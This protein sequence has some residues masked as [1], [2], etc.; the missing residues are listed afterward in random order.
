[1]RKSLLIIALAVFTINASAQVVPSPFWT[2]QS[3]NFSIVSAGIRYMHVVDPNVVWAVGYNGTSAASNFNEFTRTINGGTSYVSGLIYP[4]TAT[5]FPASIE[6]INADTAW[7]TAYLT[8]GNMGAIHQ[9]TN[10]GVSWTN[11]TPANMFTNSI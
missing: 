7:V 6:A 5:Y 2:N 10:G 4:T 3:S 1:M 8:A 11:M 9:T